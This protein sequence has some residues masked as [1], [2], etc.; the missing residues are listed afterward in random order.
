MGI[1]V[2]IIG[3]IIVLVLNLFVAWIIHKNQFDYEPERAE[4]WWN[5]ICA[6][7]SCVVAYATL[8]DSATRFLFL[9]VIWIVYCKVPKFYGVKMARHRR[10]KSK[11]AISRKAA[12]GGASAIAKHFRVSQNT[13][14][15]QLPWQPTQKVSKRKVP[16]AARHRSGH[17]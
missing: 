12:R 11:K 6:L 13:T 4:A 3:I 7:I 16:P 10:R 1:I 2:S 8:E 15:Y 17:R 5:I 14:S 9:A